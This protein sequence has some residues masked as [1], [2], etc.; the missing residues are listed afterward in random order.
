M[1]YSIKIT[2]KNGDYF[3]FQEGECRT[4]T[5]GLNTRLFKEGLPDSD[6]DK[7]IIINLGSTK[8]VNF[9]FNLIETTTDASGGSSI[10]TVQEKIDYIEGTLLTG[11]A[12]DIY[13][14]DIVTNAGSI[15]GI[16]GII[17][18]YSFD[19]TAERPSVLPGNFRFSVGGNY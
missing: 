1:A 4:A 3:L 17:E 12:S 13:T 14:I 15:T 8:D 6:A 16:K 9:A 11:G 5:Y 10:N 19:F 7:A 2:N 18:A